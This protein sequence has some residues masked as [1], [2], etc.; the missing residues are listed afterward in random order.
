[1]GAIMAKISNAT[2][3]WQSVTLTNEEVWYVHSG[4][5]ALDTEAV[6]ADRLGVI[7]GPMDWMIFSAGKTVYYRLANGSSAL[8]ARVEN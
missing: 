6:E 4:S 3:A 2:A 8:I 5:V 7:C 1:M